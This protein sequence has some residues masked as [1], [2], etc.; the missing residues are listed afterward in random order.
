MVL[1]TIF[2][3]IFKRLRPFWYAIECGESCWVPLFSILFTK[4]HTFLPRNNNKPGYE[5]VCGYE[6]WT[7]KRFVTHDKMRWEIDIYV[8]SDDFSQR[9]EQTINKMQCEMS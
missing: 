7:Y 3:W 5:T 8:H 6:N 9:F 1:S 4:I 2:T